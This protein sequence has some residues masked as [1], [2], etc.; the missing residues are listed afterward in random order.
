M[1]MYK[2]TTIVAR[3]YISHNQG[4]VVVTIVPLDSNLGVFLYTF[5]CY[6]APGVLYPCL[7]CL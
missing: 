5:L 1:Q 3:N 7:A 2:A 4:I 6:V